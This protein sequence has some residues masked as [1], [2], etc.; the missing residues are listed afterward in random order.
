MITGN[1]DYVIAKQLPENHE[2]QNPGS[3]SRGPHESSLNVEK[4]GRTHAKYMQ[5]IH[6]YSSDKSVFLKHGEITE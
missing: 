5:S 3:I 6:Q 1:A 2:I 4:V